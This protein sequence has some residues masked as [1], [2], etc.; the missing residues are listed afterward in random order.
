MSSMLNVLGA[1][2]AQTIDREETLCRGLLRLSIMDHLMSVHKMDKPAQHLAYL[3]TMSFSDW[4]GVLEGKALSQ[5]LAAL[6]IQNPTSVT[7]QL[8]Q[9][10]VDKQSLLTMSAR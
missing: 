5:R 6:G 10:L 7:V 3:K 1:S 4:A 2:L 9:T 8:K